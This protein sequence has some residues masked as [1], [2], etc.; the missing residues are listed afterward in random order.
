[1]K[2]AVTA[3]GPSTSATVDP[4]F[5]RCAYFLLVESDDGS[6]EAVE[7]AGGAQGGG[8]G[9]QA[10][11]LVAQRGAKVVLTG[12]VGPNAYQALEAAGVEVVVGCSG[13]AL[14]A[15][16]LFQSGQLR[17]ATG[18]NAASHAGTGATR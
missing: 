13:T 3:A 2:I 9:I 12:S 17:A 18:P 15:I 11:R 8:A 4:R 7:N 14:Q 6:F 1:V 10:A 5:G 16:E